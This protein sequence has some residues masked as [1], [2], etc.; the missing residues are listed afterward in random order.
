[1]S[2]LKSAARTMRTAAALRKAMRD[3]LYNGS[4]TT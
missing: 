3:Y 2:Q 1:L 4:R